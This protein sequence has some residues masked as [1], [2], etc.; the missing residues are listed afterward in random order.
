MSLE[1][2]GGGRHSYRGSFAWDWLVSGAQ[3]FGNVVECQVLE[4]APGDGGH[5]SSSLH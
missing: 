3:I 5:H 1:E 4:G 2:E